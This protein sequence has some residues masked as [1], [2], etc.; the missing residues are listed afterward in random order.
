MWH[1]LVLLLQHE[2]P[3]RE[4]TTQRTAGKSKQRMEPPLDWRINPAGQ[5]HD[6]SGRLSPQPGKLHRKNQPKFRKPVRQLA[7]MLHLLPFANCLLHPFARHRQARSKVI[8]TND[9][10]IEE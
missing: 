2:N 8:V 6:E 9:Y 1:R 5:R 3:G 7:H 10:S 4:R